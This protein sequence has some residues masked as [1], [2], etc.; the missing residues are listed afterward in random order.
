MKKI[1]MVLVQ[2]GT[3]TMGWSKALLDT[4]REQDAIEFN[5][6]YIPLL[7]TQPV[8]LSDFFIGVFPVTCGEWREVMGSNPPLFK[9][10]DNPVEGVSWNDA[11][12]FIARLNDLTGKEYRLPTEAEWEYAARGGQHSKEYLFSGSND[13]EEVGWFKSSPDLNEQTRPVGLKKPNEL[14]LYDM[15]GNVWEW[16]WDWYLPY[17][18]KLKHNPKGALQGLARSIRGGC[19]H[20]KHYL[21]QRAAIVPMS[22]AYT[23]GFRLAMSANTI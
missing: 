14:G 17:D 5:Q 7:G 21:P 8:S 6:D 22:T 10:D 12:V 23:T 19:I 13:I 20:T 4:L 15:T 11:Q 16:C 2:G 1:E 9:G 3:Y 18:G